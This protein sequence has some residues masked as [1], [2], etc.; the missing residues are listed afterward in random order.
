MVLDY[1][2]WDKLETS[3]DDVPPPPPPPVKV[4]EARW[5]VK[6]FRTSPPEPSLGEGSKEVSSA[7][8]QTAALGLSPCKVAAQ[9]P[10]CRQ[11]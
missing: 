10:A 5:Q 7:K 4:G 11:G 9:G 2:K 6:Q 1:S 8:A 3:D